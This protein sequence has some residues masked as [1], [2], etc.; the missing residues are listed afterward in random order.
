MKKLVIKRSAWIHTVADLNQYSKLVRE[1]DGKKCCLGFYGQ[2]CGI[3]LKAME[4]KAVFRPFGESVE[5]YV[6][7]LPPQMQ[8]LVE[9]SGKPSKDAY[10]LMRAN[11]NKEYSPKEKEKLIANYFK[12][13]DVLVTFVD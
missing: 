3:P 12:K 2:A 11:D 9:D 13:H 5:H 6:K 7:Q 1:V 10:D 4:N 8:W